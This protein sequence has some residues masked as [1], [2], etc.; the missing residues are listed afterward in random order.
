MHGY[1]NWHMSAM[2]MGGMGYWWLLI[3]AGIG[4]MIAFLARRRWS[5]RASPE[6]VLKRRFAEGNIDRET[7]DRLRAGLRK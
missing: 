6:Q 5:A 3:L 1:G 4:V 2:N 7:Y